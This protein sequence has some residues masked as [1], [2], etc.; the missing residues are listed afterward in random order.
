MADE[1]SL[2]R[3]GG[4]A[5]VRLSVTARWDFEVR[6][7][8]D[9]LAYV[10]KRL[11]AER[12]YDPEAVDQHTR[13]VE[14]ALLALFELDSWPAD[15]AKAGLVGAGSGGNVERVDRTLFE[16]TDDERADS[17]F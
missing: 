12:G 13:N 2:V 11:A 5:P 3:K 17:G 8:A 16:M 10:R 15:Y 1:M 7:E 14:Q 6:D 4:R 9:F